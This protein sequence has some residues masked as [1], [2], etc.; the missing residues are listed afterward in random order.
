MLDRLVAQI[1]SRFD[2]GSFDFSILK[3]QPGALNLPHTQGLRK[4]LT[5]I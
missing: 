1:L 4:D 3:G 2:F 5:I